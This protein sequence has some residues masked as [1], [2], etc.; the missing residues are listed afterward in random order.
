MGQISKVKLTNGTYV[1]I[2]DSYARTYI[3]NIK[4]KAVTAIRVKK[5]YLDLNPNLIL[6]NNQILIIEDYER[7]S[8][9]NYVPAI[10]IGDGINTISNLPVIGEYDS[11]KLLDHISNTIIHVTEED[12]K[13]WIFTPSLQSF[14]PDPNKVRVWLDTSES[15]DTQKEIPK[16]AES[17]IIEG[18]SLEDDTSKDVVADFNPDNGRL[19]FA[20]V[21]NQPE[22]TKFAN[23]NDPV[24]EV[25]FAN[26]N[27]KGNEQTNFAN[28]NE[29][30]GETFNNV[31]ETEETMFKNVNESNTDE[32]KLGE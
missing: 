29:E 2:A 16:E 13:S 23:V 30:S 14:S 27:E 3:D 12:R 32:L 1:D 20:N 6:D 22:E 15:E 7:D 8:N 11:K 18:E 31:N 28:V 4:D 17:S 24:I 25:T 26:V 9:G 10:K 5:S 21:N 19:S